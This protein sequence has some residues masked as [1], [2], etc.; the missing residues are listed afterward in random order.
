MCVWGGVRQSVFPDKLHC[1]DW[2]PLR[3]QGV[4]LQCSALTVLWL[5]AIRLEMRE[6]CHRA[7]RSVSCILEAIR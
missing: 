6:C 2:S 5:E 7:Q 3:E 4:L 1:A